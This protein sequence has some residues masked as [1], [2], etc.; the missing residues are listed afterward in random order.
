MRERE[1]QGEMKREIKEEI[2]QGKP[3]LKINKLEPT[4]IAALQKQ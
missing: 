4:K 1:R 2:K 3:N